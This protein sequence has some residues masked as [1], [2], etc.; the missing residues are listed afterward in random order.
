MVVGG[1]AAGVY[2]AIH[3][4]TVAPDLG[5]VIIEKGKPLTKVCVKMVS[6]YSIVHCSHLILFGSSHCV[7]R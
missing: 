1:G 6:C 3:A 2:G 5:V 7:G 4:K